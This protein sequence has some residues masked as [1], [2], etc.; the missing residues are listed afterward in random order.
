MAKLFANRRCSD[1]A[2]C[3]TCSGSAVFANN[4]FGGF[5]TKNGLMRINKCQREKGYQPDSDESVHP[6]LSLRCPLELC[7]LDCSQRAQHRLISLRGV[8]AGRTRCKI[9]FLTLCHRCETVHERVYN[10]SSK[11]S[12]YFRHNL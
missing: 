12:T 3:G 10:S 9:G 2:F 1:T 8:F 5:Q 11:V 6:D 4:P 7:I